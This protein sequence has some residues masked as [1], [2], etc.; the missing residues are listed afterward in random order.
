LI[1][2]SHNE[3]DHP[4]LSPLFTVDDTRGVMMA[5]DMICVYAMEASTVGKQ[6]DKEAINTICNLVTV[7]LE[8]LQMR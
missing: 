3:T 8:I 4:L 1:A 7:K 5:M 6:V 2:S